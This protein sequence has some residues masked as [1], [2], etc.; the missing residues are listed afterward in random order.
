[1]VMVGEVEDASAFMNSKQVMIV[2]LHAGSGIRV[3]LMEGMALGKGIVSTTIG[4]EGLPVENEKNIF[5][6]DEATEF[7]F[8]VIRLLNDTN[9]RIDMEQEARVLAENE[10][11]Y[12]L[13]LRTALPMT[14]CTMY[15]C[16]W[17]G[18][19]EML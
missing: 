2:P 14:H 17:W 5:I 13:H 4:A 6:G 9:K 7:S 11:D 8:A 3:K 18:L 12:L 19:G 1:M 16:T 15:V 10:F